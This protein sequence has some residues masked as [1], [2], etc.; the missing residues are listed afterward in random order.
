MFVAV[1]MCMF[2]EVVEELASDEAISLI[3][4]ECVFNCIRRDKRDACCAQHIPSPN[5]CIVNIL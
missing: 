1:C 2:E 5:N 4:C 3:V